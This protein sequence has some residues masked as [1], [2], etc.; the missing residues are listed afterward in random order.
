M[1]TARP[2]QVACASGVMSFPSPSQVFQGQGPRHVGPVGVDGDALRLQPGSEGG[3]GLA[4]GPGGPQ[5]GGDVAEL[6]GVAF[7]CLDE[8]GQRFLVVFDYLDNAAG[9]SGVLGWLSFSG[10]GLRALWAL[11]CLLR[12]DA[13]A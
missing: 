12:S 11:A 3:L 4:L 7:G 6:A 10:R 8:R 5:L 2:G 1:V 9:A 13:R